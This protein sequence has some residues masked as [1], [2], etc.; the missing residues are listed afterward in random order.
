MERV[1]ERC[2]YAKEFF[3]SV[4]KMNEKCALNYYSYF[5]FEFSRLFKNFP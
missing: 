4:I 5:V 1:W 2:K 3:F